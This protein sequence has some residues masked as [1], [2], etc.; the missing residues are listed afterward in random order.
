MTPTAESCRLLRPR[1]GFVSPP[2]TPDGPIRAGFQLRESSREDV[3][4]CV[5]VPVKHEPAGAGVHAHAQRFRDA[6]AARRAVLTGVSRVDLDDVT[7]SFFRFLVQ[8]TDEPGPALVVA[9]TGEH[10]L[11]EPLDVEILDADRVVALDQS[12]SGLVGVATADVRLTLTRLGEQ[13]YGFAPPFRP[14]FASGDLPLGAPDG[15]AS[16][17]VR[18][19]SE[20]QLTVAGR[21]ERR[22]PDIHADGAPVAGSG[23]AGTSLRLIAT[24]QRPLRRV[25]RA[26]HRAA[27]AGTWRCSLTLMCPTPCTRRRPASVSATPPALPAKLYSSVSKR[28]RERK[29]G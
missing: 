25:I 6:P 14:T 12:A 5:D 26:S 1:T 2:L 10:A 28:S 15:L 7:S 21:G 13:D 3:A 9:V 23:R 22:D 4:C 11:R 29:R 8:Q 19:W 18:A 20:D 24:Y 16:R 17:A 27:P